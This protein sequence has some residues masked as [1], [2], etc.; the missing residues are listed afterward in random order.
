M[1]YI[2]EGCLSNSAI[3]RNSE[4]KC[5]RQLQTCLGNM[6]D[7]ENLSKTLRAEQRH[8]EAAR[9]IAEK[10]KAR[11][12]RHHRAFKGYRKDLMRLWDSAAF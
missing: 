11:K 1:R 12:S 7:E 6:H 4:L 2:L 9:D 5:L 3:V 10:I 8:H